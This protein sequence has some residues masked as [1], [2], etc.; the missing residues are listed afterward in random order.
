MNRRDAAGVPVNE[1]SLLPAR[2]TFFPFPDWWIRR[3]SAMLWSDRLVMVI[4]SNNSN[5]DRN[6]SADKEEDTLWKMVE[7]DGLG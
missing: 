1:L 7:N 4:D 3:R 2:N 5:N 6:N